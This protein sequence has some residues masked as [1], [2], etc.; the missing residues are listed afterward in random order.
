MKKIL[1]FTLLLCVISGAAYGQSSRA[2]NSIQDDTDA[3]EID[4]KGLQVSTTEDSTQILEILSDTVG[5]LNSVNADSTRAANIEIDLYSG[6]RTATTTEDLSQAA[7]AYTLFTG[8]TADVI[9][10][11]ITF[12][13]A[14]VDCSDDAT[15]TGISI[16]TDDVTN[17]VFISQA[18]GVKANLTSEAEIAWTGSAIIKTGTIIQATIYGAAADAAT[19]ADFFVTYRPVGATG[20]LVP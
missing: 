5:L 1:L 11:S 10:E 20:S 18:D 7:A 6:V 2:I 16:H 12:R 4:T 17:T 14:T 19:V 9:L 3:I 15:F 8:T 13:N